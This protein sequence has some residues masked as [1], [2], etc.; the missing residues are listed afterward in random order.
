MLMKEVAI[1]DIY[2]EILDG[3]RNKFPPNTWK[4]DK[5]NK[6]A[7][8]IIT[9]LLNSI[10]KWNKEDIRKKWN[11]KLI[12]KYRLRGLLKHRYEN[13]PFKAINDLYPNQFKEWEFGMTPLNYWTKEKAL[14][15][16]KWIIEE[17]EGLSQEKLLGVYGKKWLKKNKLS[18]PLAMYWNSSPY[19]MINDL[20]P[21]RFK[22]WEFG[23]TPNNFWTKEK[24]LEALKWSI[25][26]K[27]RLTPKQ[28]LDIY[29]IK[30]LKTHGL[31]S[32][33]QLIWGNSPFRMINDLYRDRFKEWEFRVTPV[34]YW[35]KR[36]ALEA[37]RW[38]IEEKEKLDEKQLLQVFNQ[39][40]L[41]EQK[42]WTPLKRYWKGSPYEMLNALYPNRFSKN[43]LKGYI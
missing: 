4:E 32:A 10:L 39:K 5:D 25:E 2:Q 26:E 40:W 15:I 20:Y 8:R 7:R 3:K 43:M 35:S 21:R 33:C 34:G 11:T 17:K 37:L 27:E 38:T 6:M 36:K 23:M 41:I 24:A 22:E 18:A 13:S 19:A 14:T 42:L 16:L 30:W 28:L 29:N 1:E 12:V 31:A 9:Y